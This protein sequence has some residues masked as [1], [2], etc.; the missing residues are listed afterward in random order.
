MKKIKVLLVINIIQVVLLI[1]SIVAAVIVLPNLIFFGEKDVPLTIIL[2]S[3]DDKYNGFAQV[4][5]YGAVADDGKDDTEA[6][7]KALETNASVYVP[8]GTFDVSETLVFENKTL[9]GCGSANTVIRSS[10]KDVA[11]S[12]SGSCVVEDLSVE[13]AEGSVTGN[14]KQGEKV[15]ILDNSLTNG[16]MILGVGFKNVGTGFA[17]YRDSKGA[18]CTTIEAVTFSEYSYRAIEIK[19]GLSTVIR[20]ASIG[21]PSNKTVVPV[22]LGGVVTIESI[23]FNAA[24]C[25]YALERKN[26]TA[27]VIRNLTYN[28][29]K[30]SSNKLFKADSARFSVQVTTLLSTECAEIVSVNDKEGAEVPTEGMI[31]MVYHDLE[32]IKVS[33]NSAVKYE[34]ILK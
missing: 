2:G 29:V 13:F 34:T 30:A 25:E 18:F 26:S 16:S 17:S 6:F 27:V 11:V 4:T 12:L 23:S 8:I 7:R 31:Y 5:S 1:A 14:E 21:N 3:E 19:N 9:K 32:E 15:A 28:A 24:E 10:A 22:S 20:S 33:N